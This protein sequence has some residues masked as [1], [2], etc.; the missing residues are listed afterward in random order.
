MKDLTPACFA[1]T[2][3]NGYQKKD[4]RSG[5]LDEGLRI[6]RGLSPITLYYFY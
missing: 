3:S 1:C 5:L 6:K 4:R 2:V